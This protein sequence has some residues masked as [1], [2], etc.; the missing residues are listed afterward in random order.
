MKKTIVTLATVSLLLARGSSVKAEWIRDQQGKWVFHENES[1][2]LIYSNGD[3][4]VVKPMNFPQYYQTDVRWGSKRY[5]ISNMKITGCV[6]TSLAMVISTL[7]ESVTPE[8]VADYIYDTTMEM[9]TMFTGTS[10]LGAR[11]AITYWG[12][13]YQVIDSKEDLEAAL[14]SGKTVYGAVG[15]GIFVKG[16]STHAILLSGYDHGKTRAT[17]PDNPNKTNRWYN[18]EDIWNERSLELEDNAV[19]GPF[20]AVYK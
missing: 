16:Y 7:V 15:H 11:D 19:G 12:L 1:E 18:V 8:Q 3:A 5:G 20:M 17:D 2:Q 4:Q 6:P 13:K 14:K 10:S 9:N